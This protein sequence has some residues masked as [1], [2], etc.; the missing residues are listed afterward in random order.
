LG[1]ELIIGTVLKTATS[2]VGEAN[3]LLASVIVN[4]CDHITVPGVDNQRASM[5]QRGSVPGLICLGKGM[6]RNSGKMV[7]CSVLGLLPRGV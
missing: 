1:L 4:L 3:V 2:R 5:H 7:P 6:C